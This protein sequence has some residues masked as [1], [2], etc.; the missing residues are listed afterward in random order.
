MII[1]GPIGYSIAPGTPVSPPTAPTLVI[2]DNG[3]DTGATATISGSDAGSSNII[4]TAPY[5]SDTWTNSGNRIGDGDV[6]LPDL[7]I[8]YYFGFCESTDAGGM[9]VS[10]MEVFKVTAAAEAMILQ[11]MEAMES[12]MNAAGLLDSDAD[13]FTAEVEIP[14]VF[15]NV[16]TSVI[17]IFPDN[18]LIEPSHSGLNTGEYRINVAICERSKTEAKQRNQMLIREQIKDLFVGSRLESLKLVYCRRETS[19]S[20][21]DLDELF[22]QFNWISLITFELTTLRVRT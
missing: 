2:T 3:D 6:D 14:P 10:N 7:N 15:D 13:P 17:K 16:K 1:I 21:V 19:P 8:G 20:A 18:D 11:I 12:Q 4:Y 5:G 9:S 22:D